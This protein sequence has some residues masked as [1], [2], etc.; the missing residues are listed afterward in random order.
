MTI[1]PYLYHSA[2]HEDFK[3]IEDIDDMY[4]KIEKNQELLSREGPSVFAPSG[5]VY[6][7]VDMGEFHQGEQPVWFHATNCL[8]VYYLFLLGDDP[9]SRPILQCVRGVQYLFAC[10]ASLCHDCVFWA[11]FTF[12]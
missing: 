11:N 4:A 3:F 12:N 9:P 8:S 2:P 6:E 7:R 10:C 5:I 1:L